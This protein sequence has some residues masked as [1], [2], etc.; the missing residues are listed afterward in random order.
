MF[1]RLIVEFSVF[2]VAAT[3]NALDTGKLGLTG[4]VIR[5]IANP[6]GCL[7]AEYSA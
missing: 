5:K 6:G 3:Q 2:G 4:T 1:A 7:Q